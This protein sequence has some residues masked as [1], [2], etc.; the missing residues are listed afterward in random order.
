MNDIKEAAQKLG[1]GLP[2]VKRYLPVAFALLVVVIYGFLVYQVQV[3]N[4]R[5]PSDQDVQAQS[6]TAQVPHIDP[7][8]LSQ[9]KSLQDNSVSVRSF[10]DN[11]RS[12]PFKE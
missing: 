12:N 8:A 2:A 9:L 4:S 7:A 10:F 3:L 5:E 11:A 1:N 6:R